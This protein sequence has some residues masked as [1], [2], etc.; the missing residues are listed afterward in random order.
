MNQSRKKR[1]RRAWK[2]TTRK[3]LE[4]APY[5]RETILALAKIGITKDNRT[6]YELAK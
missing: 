3:L 1:R 6:D 5:K 4:L 2:Q